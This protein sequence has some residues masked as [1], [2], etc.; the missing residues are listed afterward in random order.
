M[1]DTYPNAYG[2]IDG[3]PIIEVSS[4][5]LRGGVH[6]AVIDECPLCGDNHVHGFDNGIARMSIRQSQPTHRG[7]HCANEPGGYWLI[8]T[9]ETENITVED[10]TFVFDG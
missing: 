4:V 10:G 9:A 1:S 5:E 2:S 6:V 7:A 8:Y 3:Q